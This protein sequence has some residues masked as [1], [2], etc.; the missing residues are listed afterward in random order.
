MVRSHDWLSQLTPTLWSEVASASCPKKAILTKIK[1]RESTKASKT[2]KPTKRDEAPHKTINSKPEIFWSMI[3]TAARRQIGKTNLTQLVSHLW[4]VDK[5]FEHLNHQQHIHPGVQ[6]QIKTSLTSLCD[7]PVRLDLYSI[8][9]IILA[10]IAA[11]APN[12]FNVTVSQMVHGNY[13]WD[14]FQCWERKWGGHNVNQLVWGKKTPENITGILT[15]A[16]LCLTSTISQFHIPKFLIVNS[17]QT[18]AQYSAGGQ[19]TYAPIGS[20]QVDVI[21]KDEKLSFT[22]MRSASTNTWEECIKNLLAIKKH[23][24]IIN[25]DIGVVVPDA[26]EV[27]PIRS[28]QLVWGLRVDGKDWANVRL[29]HF[30]A[31]MAKVAKSRPAASCFYVESLSG[32]IWIVKQDGSDK[33]SIHHEMGEGQYKPLS[34]ENQALL[35]LK[36]VEETTSFCNGYI[37]V[38]DDPSNPKQWGLNHGVYARSKLRPL[39]S[40]NSVAAV[41]TGLESVDISGA[42]DQIQLVEDP[43]PTPEQDPPLRIIYSISWVITVFQGYKKHLAKTLSSVRHWE[44]EDCLT[45]LVNPLEGS[46]ATCNTCRGTFTSFDQLQKHINVH[47][48]P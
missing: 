16:A 35:D 17:D 27:R 48:P 45:L 18:G 40:T 19:E 23:R 21:G 42:Q 14:H 3:E 43:V 37:V 26:S 30:F 46:E 28:G 34:L 9:A 6:T 31:A 7:T 44:S 36:W 13:I 29:D 20:K 15:D 11:K 2:Y 24:K 38:L 32:R 5:R 47:K 12:I 8:C 25:V 10:I 4:Q 22:L 39:G 41:T 1:R 33:W